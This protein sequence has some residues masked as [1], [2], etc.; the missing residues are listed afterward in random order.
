M[1][2]LLVAL[3][4]IF[5]PL[6]AWAVDV[7]RVVSPG[8]IEAWLVQDHSNPVVSMRFAFDGGS[9]LDPVGKAGLSN[10]AASTMDEGAGDLDSQSFQQILADQS[11][12]LR[13]DAGLDRFSGELKT[14][15][16]NLDQ[17]FDLLRL[18][19]SQPRFDEEPV[20]RLKSQIIAGIRADSEDPGKLAYDSLFAH[21]FPGHGYAVDSD[22]TVESVTA[23]GSDDLRSFV[24]TRLGRSNLIIG[25]VGDIDPDRL[26]QLI[27]HAFGALPA[28]PSVERGGDVAVNASG[29]LD[30]I[31]RD[32][33]QSTIVFGHG[34]LKR[35]DPD[36]YAT[37][38]MNHILGGGSFT[39]RLYDEVR[40][41]RGLAYSVGSS[42][43]P[44]DHAGLIIGSAATE[45][46]RVS[47]TIEV[48]RTQWA[49]MAAGDVGEQELKDAKTY[50]T[51]AFPLT[52][53]STGAIARVLVAMQLNK[54]GIDYLDK[55]KTYIDAVD[56]A[57]VKR[58]AAKYLAPDRLDIVVVGKPAG[59]VPSR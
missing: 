4:I 48:I 1:K 13:F 11:I 55:R 39:S 35:D 18:S 58:V 46:A 49:R 59:I 51:G 2:K 44:L 36:Y 30:V 27:D 32:I 22:G 40:E 52:F 33:P 10:L 21:F 5:A 31:E 14:L 9:E 12:T 3:M 29:R 8:G 50:I 54:L 25:V 24:K 43:Y 15:S 16:E 42:V 53:T 26:G 56:M 34:A 6:H 57:D 28:A 17:S 20:A 38:V 7:E 23:L 47:E 19:L 45:N 41:K 37:L